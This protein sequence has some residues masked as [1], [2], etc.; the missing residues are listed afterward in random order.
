MTENEFARLYTQLENEEKEVIDKIVVKYTKEVKSTIEY[1]VR[2]EVTRFYED[3]PDPE[4][5]AYKYNRT[6]SLYDVLKIDIDLDENLFHYTISPENMASN[7]GNQIQRRLSNEAIFHNSLELGWHGGAIPK[8]QKA[9]TVYGSQ[10]IPG[11][12]YWRTRDN[13]NWYIP[14]KVMHGEM[15]IEVIDK[16]TDKELS[17]LYREYQDKINECGDK[18]KK[19]YIRLIKKYMKEK[20]D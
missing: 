8:D 4:D 10:V 7:Y 15:P 14:A 3:Y 6:Y 5:V 9:R 18:Y 17:K 2:S 12:P 13:R 19:K 11:I 20:E 16:M 1:I